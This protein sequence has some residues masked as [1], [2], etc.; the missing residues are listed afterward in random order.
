MKRNVLSWWNSCLVALISDLRQAGFSKPDRQR[1]HHAR[2]GFMQIPLRLLFAESNSRQALDD[3]REHD[4]PLRPGQR[5]ADAEMNSQTKSQMAV[6]LSPN[7]KPLRFRKVSRIAIGR[8]EHLKNHLP[9][10]NLLATQF[11][12]TLHQSRLAGD[13]AFVTQ[14]FLERGRKQRRVTAQGLPLIGVPQ[15]SVQPV[16]DQGSG[17]FVARDE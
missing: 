12:V 15:Q 8:V 11:R 14:H 7:V 13:G 2:I 5:G 4:V 17:G 6:V 9:L 10:A 1:L 3:G 16:A